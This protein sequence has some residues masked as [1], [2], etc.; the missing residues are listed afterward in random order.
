MQ[1]KAI[2]AIEPFLGHRF[3]RIRAI[4]AEQLYLKLSEEDVEDDLEEL[5]LGTNWTDEGAPALAA[6]AISLLKAAV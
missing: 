3:P 6:K 5:L 2:E 1:L 4:T